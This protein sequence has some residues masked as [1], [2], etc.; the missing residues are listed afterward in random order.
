MSGIGEATADVVDQHRAGAIASLGDRGSHRVDADQVP[1][2][3]QRL[4]H[5]QHPPGLL[6]LVDPLRARPRGLTTD[7][8]EVGAVRDQLVPVRDRVAVVEPASAVGERVR[9]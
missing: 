7:V 8:D 4:D 1:G 5:R 2:G 9:A 6:G 3:G